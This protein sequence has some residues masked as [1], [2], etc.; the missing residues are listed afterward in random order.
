MIDCMNDETSS[1]DERCFSPILLLL[2]TGFD[3]CSGVWQF[4]RLRSFERIQDRR[5]GGRYR[6]S[7]LGFLS[8]LSLLLLSLLSLLLLSCIQ[9]VYT[10]SLIY[11]KLLIL[12]Y[13]EK[14][15]ILPTYLYLYLLQC[16]CIIVFY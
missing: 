14:L 8:F 5:R 6:A 15:L 16:F 11:E 1:E 7:K 13:E 2:A 9:L 12:C 4:G 10:P 3:F